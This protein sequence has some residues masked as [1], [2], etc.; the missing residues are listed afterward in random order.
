MMAK[1][2]VLPGEEVAEAEEYLPAEGTYEEEG[3]VYASIAGE[4]ELDNKEK[5]AR[6]KPFNPVAE[7]KP[8]DTVFCSVTDVRNCMVICD[9]VAIEGREREIAGETSATIHISKL[10]SDYVQD[11]SKE[12]RPSDIIRAKVIQVKPSV[13]LTT[14]GPH[15]GVV[16]ALC[17]RCRAPLIR[18]DK[19]LYCV[20]CERIETRKI[21]DDYGDVEF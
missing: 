19:G 18:K 16:K 14:A 11:A 8:G 12:I 3:K 21:A 15:L 6:V 10:S 2:S 4:L 13:Q 5:V 1:R 7:L 20:N 17:R 9:V